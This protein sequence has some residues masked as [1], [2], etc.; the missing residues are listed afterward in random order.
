[1]NRMYAPDTIAQITAGT[2]SFRTL[3]VDISGS[4]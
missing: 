4:T 3:P 1:M 2:F